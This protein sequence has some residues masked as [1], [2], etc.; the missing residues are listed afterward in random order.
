MNF[1]YVYLLENSIWIPLSKHHLFCWK[2]LASCRGG[3]HSHI[4]GAAYVGLLRPP[5]S[6][7]LSPKWLQNTPLSKIDGSHSMTL[8]FFRYVTRSQKFFTIIKQQIGCFEW[9]W[10][11]FSFWNLNF[12]ISCFYVGLKRLSQKGQNYILTQCPIILD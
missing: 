11:Q 12:N 9:F 8:F 1:S 7:P 4:G 5:F 3:G 6:A 10:A 2:N